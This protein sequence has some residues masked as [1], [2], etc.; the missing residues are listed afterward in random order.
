M[1][2]K[3]QIYFIK[4]INLRIYMDPQN[5]RVQFFRLTGGPL[6]A[7][8]KEGAAQSFL[9]GAVCIDCVW[10]AVLWLSSSGVK[11]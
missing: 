9:S 1:R 11:L 10:A 6:G 5:V 3:R 4:K 7:G 2:K 8:E